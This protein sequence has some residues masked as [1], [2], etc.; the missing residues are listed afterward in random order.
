[1]TNN[2]L[3]FQIEGVDGDLK[4]E[5][6]AFSQKLYQNGTEVKRKG[7]KY[8]VKN[9]QGNL[10][11]LKIV[12]GLDYRHK[13][14]FRGNKIFLEEKLTVLQYIMGFIPYGLIFVGGFIGALVG[15]FGSSVIFGYIR[16]ENSILKQIILAI[17]VS[18]ICTVVYFALASSFLSLFPRR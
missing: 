1:M 3:N 9:D 11:E 15:I 5:Y 2:T 8:Q 13:A 18:A 17:V 7:T 14:E 12:K 6:G 4:L 10:E 16:K